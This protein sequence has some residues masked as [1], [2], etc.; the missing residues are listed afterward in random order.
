ME[1]Y[2]IDTKPVKLLFEANEK[3]HGG[4]EFVF[5]QTLDG[6]WA[7]TKDCIDY[8]DDKY[9]KEIVSCAKAITIQEKTNAISIV[10]L[11]TT[12]TI[13]KDV[14]FKDFEYEIVKDPSTLK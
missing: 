3:G 10:D 11:M 1:Y 5:I 13:E 4:C 9:K 2:V 6:R 8:I 14:K 12:A 7:I